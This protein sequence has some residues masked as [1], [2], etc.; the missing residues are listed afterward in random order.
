VALICHGRGCPFARQRSALKN[1][2][3]IALAPQLRQ[4]HLQPGATVELDITAA[5][6]VGKVA[7]FRMRSNA[8]PALSTSCLPPGSRHPVPCFH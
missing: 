4:R 6:S 8:Q 5:N 1:G 7:V 2:G 3:R